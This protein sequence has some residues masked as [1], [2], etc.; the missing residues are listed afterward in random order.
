MFRND[1]VF[2]WIGRRARLDLT[3]A[4]IDGMPRQPVELEHLSRFTT[5]VTFGAAAS[6]S[7][8]VLTLVLVQSMSEEIMAIQRAGACFCSPSRSPIS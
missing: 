5:V 1:L 3:N 2:S 4:L 6:F 8:P 7:I